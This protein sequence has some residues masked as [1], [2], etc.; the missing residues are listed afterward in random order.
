MTMMV[1]SGEECHSF[2]YLHVHKKSLTIP[3]G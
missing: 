2:K 3:N 1:P